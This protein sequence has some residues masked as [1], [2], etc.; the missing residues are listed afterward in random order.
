MRDVVQDPGCSEAPC[1]GQ[2]G[3][4]GE[5]FKDLGDSCGVAQQPASHPA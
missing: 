1:A 2:A 3:L 4:H 5:T